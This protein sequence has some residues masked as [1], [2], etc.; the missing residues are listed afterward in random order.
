MSDGKSENPRVHGRRLI[1]P[2]GELPINIESN[3][4]LPFDVT[5]AQRKSVS[6]ML[7]QFR[8]LCYMEFLVSVVNDWGRSRL[9]RYMEQMVN[10][11]GQPNI[12]LF[13][14]APEDATDELPIFTVNNKDLMRMLRHGD[15]IERFQGNDFIVSVYAIWEDLVRPAIADTFEVPVRAVESDLMGDIRII[16][17]AIIHQKG[18]KPAED[19]SKLKVQGQNWLKDNADDKFWHVTPPMR[20]SLVVRIRS[21]DLN[22]HQASRPS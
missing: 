9:L 22:I 4:V 5:E 16:R 14:G 18:L 3:F 13:Y 20:R 21:L 17:H 19:V 2:I 6:N 15:E 12:R 8:A 1:G 7:A 11:L 10:Q